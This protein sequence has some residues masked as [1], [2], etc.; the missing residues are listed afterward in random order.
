MSGT[1]AGNPRG[2]LCWT[3]RDRMHAKLDLQHLPGRYGVTTEHVNPNEIA[4]STVEQLFRLGRGA[5]HW[6]RCRGRMRHIFCHAF[7]WSNAAC[8]PPSLSDTP[9]GPTAGPR[10]AR[11]AR[12]ERAAAR[13]ARARGPGPVPRSLP[14]AGGRA[15]ADPRAPAL[16]QPSHKTKTRAP[17]RVRKKKRARKQTR[18]GKTCV[19]KTRATK[20]ARGENACKWEKNTC[21]KKRGAAGATREQEH[22]LPTRSVRFSHV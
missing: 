20:N 13:E 6:G 22:A 5:L 11:H 18:V 7:S 3:M 16:K 21:V 10:V 12:A 9:K 14:C 19:E 1:A 15:R 8:P 4:K 2:G 17:K